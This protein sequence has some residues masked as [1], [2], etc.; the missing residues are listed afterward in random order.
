MILL[1]SFKS[2]WLCVGVVDDQTFVLVV[3]VVFQ[4]ELSFSSVVVVGVELLVEV[5]VILAFSVIVDVRIDV[6]DDDNILILKVI[7]QLLYCLKLGNFSF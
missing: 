1:S 3:S 7:V 5:W 2:G 4:V 6:P